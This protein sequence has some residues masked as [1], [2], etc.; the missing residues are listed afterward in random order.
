MGNILAPKMPAVQ[1]R[2][3]QAEV[4]PMPIRDDAA[5]R[6][7]RQKEYSRISSRSGRESTNLRGQ[8]SLGQMSMADTRGGGGGG[9]AVLGGS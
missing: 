7:A 2:A 1:Q 5:E 9:S 3:Q 6:K 8:T 4:T